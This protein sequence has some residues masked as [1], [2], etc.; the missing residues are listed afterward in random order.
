MVLCERDVD[1]MAGAQAAIFTMISKPYEYGGKRWEEVGSWMNVEHSPHHPGPLL[2]EK[3]TSFLKYIYLSFSDL[4]SSTQ[5]YVIERKQIPWEFQMGPR[6]AMNSNPFC[7]KNDL[8]VEVE[9]GEHGKDPTCCR[10]SQRCSRLGVGELWGD[11]DPVCP[12]WPA[13]VQRKV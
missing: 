5:F 2:H 3:Y 1:G 6:W 4:C 9:V 12:V 7:A 11:C 8:G 13:S 10:R